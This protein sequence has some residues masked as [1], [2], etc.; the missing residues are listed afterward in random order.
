[1]DAIVKEATFEELDKDTKAKVVPFHD[2]S[3]FNSMETLAILENLSKKSKFSV[4]FIS[5]FGELSPTN[6]T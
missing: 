6:F 3:V 1:M 5:F 2:P 4:S